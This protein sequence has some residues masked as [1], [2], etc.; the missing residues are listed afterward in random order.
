M[1]ALPVADMQGAAALPALPSWF[2]EQ[3]AQQRPAASQAYA[4]RHA[5]TQA[6]AQ[7]Q[8]H[9]ASALPPTSLHGYPEMPSLDA[10]TGD[11]QSRPALPPQEVRVTNQVAL[12]MPHLQPGA[13]CDHSHAAVPQG[14]APVPTSVDIRTV[15]LSTKVMSEFMAYA[16][17]RLRSNLVQRAT[18]HVFPTL[19]LRIAL[20]CTR[21]RPRS[22]WTCNTIC[23]FV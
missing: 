3:E 7:P 16:K 14:H 1:H 10:L 5:L 9:A 18:V 21:R 6:P 8:H 17:V 2:N 22:T 23:S 4:R 15:Y 13:G 20:G 19:R 12:D 11:P